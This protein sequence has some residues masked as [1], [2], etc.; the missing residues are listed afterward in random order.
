ML[1]KIITSSNSML[2]V[3][4]NAAIRKKNFRLVVA[5]CSKL[6]DYSVVYGR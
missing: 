6:Y 3:N 1:T 2:G 4:T 5:V